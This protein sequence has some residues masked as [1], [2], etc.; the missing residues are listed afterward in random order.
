MK[1]P[2]Y[3]SFEELRALEIAAHRARSQELLRL[4]KAALKGVRH[5]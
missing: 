1:T 2:I 5:A 3:P 4:F